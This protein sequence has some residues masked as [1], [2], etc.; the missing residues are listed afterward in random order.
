MIDDKELK[1]DKIY[2]CRII[3]KKLEWQGVS[4]LNKTVNLMWGGIYL[5]S[6]KTKQ[7]L[8]LNQVEIIE[9]VREK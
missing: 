3:D 4:L 6:L 1:V 2:K 5:Y 9:E 8:T 7:T